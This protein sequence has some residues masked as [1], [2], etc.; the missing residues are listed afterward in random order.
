MDSNAPISGWDSH[1]STN[2][3]IHAPLTPNPKAASAAVSSREYGRLPNVT[4]RSWATMVD[5]VGCRKGVG[6][7]Y[8]SAM[9][10]QIL[11]PHAQ[12]QTNTAGPNWTILGP[13]WSI[14]VLNSACT[15]PFTLAAT[16]DALCH[17]ADHDPHASATLYLPSF[18]A[19]A[20]PSL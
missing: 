10:L 17:L 13:T 1:P 7:S 4:R 9:S 18:T 15:Q 12:L 6:A 5:L 16:A 20:R 2:L 3:R 14:C 11:I 19:H 8:A